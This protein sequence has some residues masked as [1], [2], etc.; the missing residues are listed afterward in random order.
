MNPKTPVIRVALEV[1]IRV[2]TDSVGVKYAHVAQVNPVCDSLIDASL[3]IFVED[4][5]YH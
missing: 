2:S 5:I 3:Y 1:A 4:S